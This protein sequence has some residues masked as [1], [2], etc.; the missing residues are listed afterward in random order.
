MSMGF[1]G[2]LTYP[3]YANL[4]AATVAGLIGALVVVGFTAILPTA[5]PFAQ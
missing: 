3:I 4:I 1:T 2:S 5:L